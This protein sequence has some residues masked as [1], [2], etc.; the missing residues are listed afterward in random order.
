M[1]AMREDLVKEVEETDKAR[2]EAFKAWD[3]AM[4][5]GALKKV[6]EACTA[7]Y[8]AEKAWATAKRALRKYNREHCE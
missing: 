7:Y 2:E 6:F 8:E 1:S 5:G 4:N 3:E